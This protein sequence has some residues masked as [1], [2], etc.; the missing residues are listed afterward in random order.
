MELSGRG[1]K[2][3]V[4]GLP[5]RAVILS[6][7]MFLPALAVSGT[8][9]ASAAP[10]NPDATVRMASSGVAGSSLETPPDEAV[11]SWSSRDFR[12][13]EPAEPQ[14]SAEAAFDVPNLRDAGTSAADGAFLPADIQQSPLRTHGKVFF[15]IGLNDFV[16][17]GTVVN[18]RGRNVVFTAGHCV[19]DTD[20]A[21]YV[22]RLV[23][24][25]AYQG[26][27]PNAE[28]FGVWAATAVFTSSRYVN[29]GELSH[30][31]GVVVLENRIEDT[32][33]ARPIAFDLNPVNRQFT[34]YGY[35][36]EPDPPYDGETM[37]GCRSQTVDRDSAEGSPFPIAAGPCDMQSG[38][39]GGGWITGSGYLNSVVS[40]GYCESSPELCGLTFGP[41][42]GDQV[43]NVYT[44]PAVGG[45]MTP[46]VTIESGPRGRIRGST[47]SFRFGGSAST[48]LSFRCRL[49]RGS[50]FQCGSRTTLRRLR[51]GAHLLRVYSVDQT[52]RTSAI[53][54]AKR[55][56]VTGSRR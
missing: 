56:S 52:G 23:F 13:A 36:V 46:T 10:G 7:F 30:D 12:E 5:V 21:Q 6:L 31:I 40:Y 3:G 49:D 16:C 53:S 11:A 20:T 18:S 35:P 38:S 39:S 54:A 34:I 29:T 44:Y 14:V 32:T 51:R 24:V 50:D 45:S 48:P 17:S 9:A 2:R 4:N 19:Y 27:Q 43:K 42:F 37:V 26:S 1:L 47:A 33:G 25:P 55:F 28:P 15:G 41:Y 22:D 8:P